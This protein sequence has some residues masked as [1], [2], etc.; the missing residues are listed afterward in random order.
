MESPRG[1]NRAGRREEHGYRVA[2]LSEILKL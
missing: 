1:G 2:F